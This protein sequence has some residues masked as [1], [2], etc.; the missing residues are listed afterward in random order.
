MAGPTLEDAAVTF[1][2]ERIVEVGAAADLIR[3]FPEARVEDLG[4]A[5][6]LPGLV[7]AHTHLELSGVQRGATPGGGFTGWLLDRIRQAPTSG[8]GSGATLSPEAAIQYGIDQC[9]RFG[10]TAVGDISRSPLLTRPILQE[11]PLRGVSYGEVRAMAQNRAALE[12]QLAEAVHGFSPA[13]SPRA[14]VVNGVSPHAPYSV[15]PEAYRRCLA[16]ARA[17][18]LSVATH[19][20]ESPDEASFLAEHTGPFRALWDAIGRWDE[21]VPRFDGGPIRF[22][23][24]LGLLDGPNLLAHVNYCDDA[25]LDLL[26]AG[27]ASVVYCPRT[28]AYFGHPPQSWREMLAPG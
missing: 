5:V 6:L 17:H 23:Q 13:G 26:A 20:A 16:A 11:S 25:E 4:A 22:A 18:G 24:N 28:H 2:G 7:N 10:V 27:N 3:R 12:S 21:Q 15:E 1:R 19:L 14:G 9:L 8:T